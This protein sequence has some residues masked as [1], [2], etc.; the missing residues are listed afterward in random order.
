MIA[1]IE[2]NIEDMELYRRT[3]L[4]GHAYKH[5]STL[6]G[7][8]NSGEIYS[9]IILDLSLPDAYGSDVVKQVSEVH[10]EKIVVIT[11]VAGDLLSGRAYANL[12][13]SGAFEVFNKGNL[14]T[15]RYAELIEEAIQDRA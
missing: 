10:E 4:K 11:G 6:K 9:A 14:L 8:L 5:F 13:K 12:I 1:V 7:F 2:D 3:I 15:P